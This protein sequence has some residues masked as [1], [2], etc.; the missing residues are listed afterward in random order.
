MVA[1]IIAMTALVS[2]AF[3]APAQENVLVGRGLY[4]SIGGCH[5]C[6]TEGYRESGRKIDPESNQG[7]YRLGWRNPLGVAYAANVRLFAFLRDQNAFVGDMKI[8]PETLPL[9]ARL[10]CARDGRDWSSLG[11]SLTH[12]ARRAGQAGSAGLPPRAQDSLFDSRSSDYAQQL[13]SPCSEHLND[14]NLTGCSVRV[15]PGADLPPRD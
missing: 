11:L 9:H 6:N 7:R 2:L 3:S 5:D 10:Q 1:E 13:I 14:V 15:V 4:L 12:V 8:L